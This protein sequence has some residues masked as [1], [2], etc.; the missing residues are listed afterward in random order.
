MIMLKNAYNVRLG[1]IGGFGRYRLRAKPF[2]VNN[3]V[4][5]NR[6]DL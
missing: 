1:E 6:T 5:I 3:T 4:R 2:K